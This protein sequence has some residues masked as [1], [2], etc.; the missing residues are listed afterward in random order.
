MAIPTDRTSFV[1]FCMRKLGAPV[2]QVNM[3]E[4]QAD[5]CVDQALYYYGEYHMD[6]AIKTYYAYAL[7]QD[8]VNNKYIT[9]PDGIIGVNRMFPLGQAISTDALFNMRYQFVMNDLYSLANVSL[10]PYFMVM[11]HIAQLEEVLVCQTPIRY[12]RH[13]NIC[14]IDIDQ[15][16][17]DAGMFIVLECYQT[18][19]PDTYPDVWK[20]LWL[21]QYATAL[22]KRQWGENLQKYNFQLPSG[23][24]INGRD[25]YAQADADVKRLE[26]KVITDYSTPPM[27]FMG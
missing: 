21:Q 16:T 17:L 11:Q 23:M 13:Q 20:D 18:V 15:T 3:S 4:D 7:T 24:T 19:D 12:N 27:P 22:M 5:D 8:D 10:V 9:L 26:D 25:I 6:G 2:I 14:Y 1:A